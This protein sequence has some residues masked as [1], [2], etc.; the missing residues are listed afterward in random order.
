M[1]LMGHRSLAVVYLSYFVIHTQA[2]YH[3]ALGPER[4]LLL[5]QNSREGYAIYLTSA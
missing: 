1:S 5:L 3:A 4:A 2:V